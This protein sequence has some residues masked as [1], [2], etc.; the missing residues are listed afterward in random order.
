MQVRAHCPYQG[1][2]CAL[3]GYSPASTLMSWPPSATSAPPPHA[4]D[5]YTHNFAPIL[6]GSLLTTPLQPFS[7]LFLDQH[8][9]HLGA[10]ALISPKP[11]TWCPSSPLPPLLLHPPSHA[12]SL[13]TQLLSF[14][15]RFP[16][17]HTLTLSSC[18]FLDYSPYDIRRHL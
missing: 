13:F 16:A 12:Y 15:L 17:H 6:L 4:Y 8:T 7:C 5:P 10:R 18:L 2:N 1:T 9:V 11:L 14:T 3:S